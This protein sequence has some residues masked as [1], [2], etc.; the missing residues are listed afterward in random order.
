MGNVVDRLGIQS[1]G[2]YFLFKITYS[3]AGNLIDV[4]DGFT[5]GIIYVE[6]PHIH[7]EVKANKRK[8]SLK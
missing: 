7:K 1:E 3:S 8:R 5:N 6:T 2:V 4:R